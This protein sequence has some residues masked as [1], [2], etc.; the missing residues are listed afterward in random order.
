M[1][2]TRRSLLPTTVALLLTLSSLLM[3]VEA[4][5]RTSSSSSRTGRKLAKGALIAIIV[6]VV[7]GVILFCVCVFCLFRCLRGRKSKGGAAP[8]LPVTEPKQDYQPNYNAAPAPGG[9]NGGQPPYPNQQYNTHQN[10]YNASYN[11]PAGGQYAPPSGPP[12]MPTPS[13]GY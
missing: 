4:K 7:V 1:I 8:V 13:G 6:C 2:S 12:M 9:Y 11:N 3:G 5:G 10:E